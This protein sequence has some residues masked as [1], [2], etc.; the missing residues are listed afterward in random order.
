MYNGQVALE[1]G[2]SKYICM[3]ERRSQCAWYS[4]ACLS[5]F[6]QVVRARA[7]PSVMEHTRRAFRSS[8]VFC[9]WPLTVP[10][11]P[12]PPTTISSGVQRSSW[13][14]VRSVCA[15][16][17]RDRAQDLLCLHVS[18]CAGRLVACILATLFRIAYSFADAVTARSA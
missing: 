15:D 4:E 5:S 13:D 8:G 17:L 7:S 14:H 18:V 3:C 9:V 10:L 16:E 1:P 6:L 12:T 11:A 2:A